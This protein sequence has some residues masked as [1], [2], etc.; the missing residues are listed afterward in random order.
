MLMGRITAI[1]I[2]STFDV[3]DICAT[4]ACPRNSR[5]R[6]VIDFESQVIVDV[7]GVR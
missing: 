5:P 2:V 3:S 4:Y 1:R 7:L 6:L